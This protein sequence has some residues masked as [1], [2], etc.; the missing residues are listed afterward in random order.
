MEKLIDIVGLYLNPPEHALVLYP[1]CVQ[2]RTGSADEKS[3]IQ[4]LDRTQPSLPMKKGRCGT[5]THNYKRNGTATQ[6][7]ALA[8]S[9]GRLIGTC[10]PRH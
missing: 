4:V 1:V 10:M 5:L 6:F 7:A 2:I 9:E 8:M 3:Q